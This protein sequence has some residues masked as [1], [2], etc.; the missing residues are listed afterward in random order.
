MRGLLL[1]CLFLT[2]KCADDQGQLTKAL[3]AA[4]HVTAYRRHD[5]VST[6]KS[7]SCFPWTEGRRDDDEEQA[8]SEC[9]DPERCP[10]GTEDSSGGITVT[11]MGG[12]AVRRP[13]EATPPRGCTVPLTQ[14]EREG[15]GW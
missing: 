15:K 3:C 7:L 8:G 1:F 2:L 14:T 13:L 9:F 11:Y 6:C 12:V 5:F 10:V 4:T